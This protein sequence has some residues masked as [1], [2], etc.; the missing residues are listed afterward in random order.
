MGYRHYLGIID[1]QKLEELRNKKYDDSWNYQEEVRENC[2][3]I[4]ELGKLYT[5]KE[6]TDV[7]YQNC[8]NLIKEK[9]DVEMFI[10][11]QKI[12]IKLANVYKGKVE[13]YF[14]D[15]YNKINFCNLKIKK[16][17][18]EQIKAIYTLIDD[19]KDK[20]NWLEATQ[21][22]EDAKDL[23][24]TWL[25]EHQMFNLMHYYLIT[26]YLKEVIVCFAY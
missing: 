26:D 3:V 1:K 15:I 21:F 18:D 13:K 14:N 22:C 9:S 11:N 10:P 23:E 19:C 17:T 20:I 25:Y 24:L 6:T 5:D 2:K 8:E 12:F 7:L 4:L 16:L